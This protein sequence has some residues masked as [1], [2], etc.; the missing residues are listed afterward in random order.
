MKRIDGIRA[1][2][3]IQ[4]FLN[5]LNTLKLSDAVKA[6][7]EAVDAFDTKIQGKIS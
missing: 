7:N 4:T 1:D 6:A 2:L 3:W 5:R